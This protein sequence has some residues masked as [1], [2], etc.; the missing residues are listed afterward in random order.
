MCDNRACNKYG[1]ASD[2]TLPYNTEVG[3]FESTTG[4]I[5]GIYGMSGP[6][7]EYAIISMIDVNDNLLSGR[8]ASLNSGFIGAYG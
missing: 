8:N 3:Y 1:T 2:I 6:I 4:N 5:S 7:W